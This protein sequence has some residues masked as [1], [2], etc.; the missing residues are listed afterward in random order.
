MSRAEIEKQIVFLFFS[1][2]FI[3]FSW[4]VQLNGSRRVLLSVCQS[5]CGA[6]GL[7]IHLNLVK[8]VYVGSFSGYL[9]E[10]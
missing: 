4:A 2:F 10:L 1:L 3:L 7:I 8:S 6:K 5:K 9:Y